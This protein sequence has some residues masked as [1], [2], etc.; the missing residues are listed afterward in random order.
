[1]DK[2]FFDCIIAFSVTVLSFQLDF[3]K[4]GAADLVSEHS[5]KCDVIC[6]RESR[7]C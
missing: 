4:A 2:K 5:Q 7:P 1:M 6:L 3:S